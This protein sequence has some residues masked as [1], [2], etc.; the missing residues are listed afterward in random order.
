MQL[1]YRTYG[2][3]QPLIIL[4]GLYGM[5]DNWVTH[6]KTLAEKFKVFIPDMR[7]HGQS[8]HSNV[9]DYSVMADDIGEFIE[10][11]K[12]ENPIIMGHSMGGKIALKYTLDHPEQISKLIIVDMNMRQYAAND[13]NDQL[14]YAM[15]SIDFSKISSRKEVEV[16]LDQ[17]ISNQRIRM[18]LMKNL[19]ATRP[20]NYAWRLN[21]TAIFANIDA[22]FEAIQSENTFNKPCLII[23]GGASNYVSDEDFVQMQKN[24]PQ[25]ILKTIPNASHWVQADEPG[26]FMDDLMDFLKGEC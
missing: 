12:L 18:F 25:A 20:G 21:L 4:H 8:G 5:S 15:L 24:F 13:F 2:E 14:L 1:F 19:Y 26:L 10:T 9:F 23:R 17:S 6:A 11:H 16:L 3:G 22:V 7:N